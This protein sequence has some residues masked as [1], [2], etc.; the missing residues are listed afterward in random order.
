[1]EDGVPGITQANLHAIKS[2]MEAA[3]VIFLPDGFVGL[4]P[5]LKGTPRA[6][7]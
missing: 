6:E 7:V 2:T 1:M 4:A 3:G 5:N